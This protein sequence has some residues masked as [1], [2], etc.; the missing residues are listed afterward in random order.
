M[1]GFDIAGLIGG[2][3]QP[4][5]NPLIGKLS[6]KLYG[7]RA[8]GTYGGLTKAQYKRSLLPY[9]QNGTGIPPPPLPMPGPFP[10]GFGGGVL[11][12]PPEED[13]G[14]Y[15][16]RVYEAA[17]DAAGAR[18]LAG[19]RGWHWSRKAGKFVKNRRM[20][21]CNPRA[22]SRAMRR[23]KGFAGFAKSCITFTKQH[24][25]RKGKK[26]CRY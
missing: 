7:S 9:G 12:V 16:R 23:V 11:N 17:Q 19:T 2:V 21:I 20:N 10:W 26:K 5:I 4:V 14:A 1:A 13:P 15:Q 25:M 8:A 3:L 18:V 22:L 24:K 6:Q